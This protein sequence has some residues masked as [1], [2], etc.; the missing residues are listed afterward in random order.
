VTRVS[1]VI[2]T[3]N[4]ANLIERAVASVL[5]QDHDDI[6]VIVVD[7]GS[8]DNTTQVLN[9]IIATDPRVRCVQQPN[10][11]APS[12]R[13]QGVAESTGDWIAFQDSDDEWS[14]EFLHAVLAHA[15]PERVVFTSHTIVFRS[16]VVE[17]VPTGP[18]TSV[19]RSL[20]RKNFVST[21]TTLMSRELARRFP[22]DV[23]L[24][25]FQDWDLWLTLV[26][27]GVE[28]LH[29]P[30][31]GAT[32]HRQSDSISEGAHARRKESL[33]RILS[34]HRSVLQTDPVALALLVMRA[35]VPDWLVDYRHRRRTPRTRPFAPRGTTL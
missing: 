10:A 13:N 34:K 31:S 14:P 12:A 5:A 25:R 20:L 27:A 22:F 29:L 1:V 35:Y 8:S 23:S 28:F 11:G 30:I 33:R 6:E 18:V 3:Y 4:R 15:H 7:D 17:T 26:E 32:V 19:R 9:S 24:A 2:P 16:G 21:Q